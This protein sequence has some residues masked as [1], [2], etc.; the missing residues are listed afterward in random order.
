MIWAFI[1]VRQEY[2]KFCLLS[3]SVSLYCATF[4]VSIKV[5][6]LVSAST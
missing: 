1:E 6:I 4:A 2:L 3:L 5:T